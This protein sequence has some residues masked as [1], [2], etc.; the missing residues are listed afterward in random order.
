MKKLLLL[1]VLGLFVSCIQEQTQDVVD[2]S[3]E[4]EEVVGAESLGLT[5]EEFKA[6]PDE[7]KEKRRIGMLLLPYL[8]LDSV[9]NKYVL[10]ITKEKALDLG[11]TEEEYEARIKEVEATN[12]KIESLMQKG[13]TIRLIN[14]MKVLQEQNNL[15]DKRESILYEVGQQQH[16]NIKTNDGSFGTDCFYPEVGKN[17]VVFYC[18]TNAALCP[19]Y[20][21]KVYNFGAWDIKHSAGLLGTTTTLILKLFGTGSKLAADLYFCTTDSYGGTANWIAMTIDRT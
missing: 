1:L 21:C 5:V 7:V 20:T 11:I 12:E 19:V 15:K 3:I 14:P 2:S 9:L 6:M 13:D 16:G 17:S 10:N 8:Q 18:I 4:Q